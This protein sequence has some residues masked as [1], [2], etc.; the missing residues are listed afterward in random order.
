VPSKGSTQAFDVGSAQSPGLTLSVGE[1]AKAANTTLR[2]V[3]FYEEQGVI[4]SS[5]RTAGRHRRFEPSELTRLRVVLTLRQG[6]MAIEEIRAMM[7]TRERHRSGGAASRELCSSLGTQLERVEALLSLFD[8][9]RAEIVVA[10]ERLLS[11]SGCQDDTR[12]RKGCTGCETFPSAFPYSE[13][14]RLLWSDKE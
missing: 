9:L 12:F 14:L 11:C 3:R 1:M 13:L 2:T 8:Q 7:A 10:R 4:R 6:G 5:Q